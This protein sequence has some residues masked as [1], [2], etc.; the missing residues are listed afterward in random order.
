M[1]AKHLT[2]IV[3]NQRIIDNITCNQRK[4]V[5]AY[6]NGQIIWEKDTSVRLSLEKEIVYLADYNI[7]EDTNDVFTNSDFK[8]G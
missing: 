4:V 7:W 6:Y 2:N 5:R 8:V 3:C 1:P